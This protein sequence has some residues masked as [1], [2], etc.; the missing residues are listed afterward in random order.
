MS[1]FIRFPPKLYYTDQLLFWG[2]LSNIPSY[3]VYHYLHSEPMSPKLTWWLQTQKIIYG[4]YQL[5]DFTI[6]DLYYISKNDRYNS[7]K[8]E[9]TFTDQEMVQSK[10]DV[11]IE[12]VIHINPEIVEVGVPYLSTIEM[13]IDD[14]VPLSYYNT[15]NH[16]KE[17][18]Q[19]QIENGLLLR[20]EEIAVKEAKKDDH[21]SYFDQER[22]KAIRQVKKHLFD[23]L[24]KLQLNLF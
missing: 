18:F 8:I 4:T 12:S 5:D 2:E 1:Y 22:R 21:F 7:P 16:R 3:F 15:F 9:F 14:L 11:F 13:M 24:I 23:Y 17:L 6:T 20:L 10:Q 19:K